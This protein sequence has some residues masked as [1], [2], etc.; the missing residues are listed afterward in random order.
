M[1][2]PPAPAL[3]AQLS[4]LCRQLDVKVVEY[5]EIARRRADAEADYRAAKARRVLTARAG[6]AKS[7]TEA[8]TIATADPSIEALHREHLVTDAMA[9][10]AQKA[11]YSLRTRIETGRSFMASERAADTLHAQGLG[12]A[13]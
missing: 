7:A 9:D 10:A 6:G 12:G 1:N 5:A 13:A 11:I 3:Q 2:R 4:E 8:E